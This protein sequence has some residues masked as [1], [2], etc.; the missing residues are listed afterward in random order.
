MQIQLI[1]TNSTS[2]GAQSTATRFSTQCP[3]IR[4]SYFW[5]GGFWKGGYYVGTTGGISEEV[6]ERYIEKT[7]HA[8]E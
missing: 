2:L 1:P 8:T 5:G 3:D 7:E 4:A 6:V